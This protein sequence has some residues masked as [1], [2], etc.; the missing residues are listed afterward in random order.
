MRSIYCSRFAGIGAWRTR[1]TSRQFMSAN[2]NEG[3]SPNRIGIDLV[4]LQLGVERGAADLK[5]FG[6]TFDVARVL[7]KRVDEDLFFG[8]TQLIGQ[9]GRRCARHRFCFG[10]ALGQ[11]GGVDD[12]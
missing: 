10:N 6:S 7:A 11:V 8:L 5:S 2:P 1:M 3:R 9:G 4:L 12:R